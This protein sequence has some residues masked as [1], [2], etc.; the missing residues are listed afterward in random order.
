M[1][2]MKLISILI[3][4]GILHCYIYISDITIIKESKK[5]YEVKSRFE[6]LEQI[7]NN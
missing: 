4:R 5:Q 6:Y 7:G 1:F 2:N 3:I